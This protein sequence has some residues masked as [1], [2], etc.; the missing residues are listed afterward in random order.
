MKTGVDLILAE[1]PVD[2]LAVGDVASHHLDPFERAAA[3]Q[4]AVRYPVAHQPDH[5]RT[6]LDQCLG[7]PRAQNARTASDERGAVAPE[8]FPFAV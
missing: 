2:D 4:L 5:V 3:H 7:Q 8:V 1:H 6:H